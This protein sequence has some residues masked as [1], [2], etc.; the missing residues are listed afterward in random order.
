MAA[1]CQIWRVWGHSSRKV[2]RG[3]KEP[4]SMKVRT[5]FQAGNGLTSTHGGGP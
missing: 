5:H 2:R 3:P 1:D 4:D